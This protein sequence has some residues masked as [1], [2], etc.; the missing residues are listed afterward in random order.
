M[1]KLELLAPAKNVE[2][3]IEAI[4][5]GADAVYI[6]ASKFGARSSASNDIRDIEKLCSHAHLYN[7]KVYAALNTIIFEHELK[8]AEKLIHQLWNAGIDALIIQDM[9]ILE[10]DIPDIPLFASTQTDNRSVEKIQLFEKVGFKRIILAREL[11]LA[12]IE[13][14]SS[15]TSI[16]LEA[17]IHGAL[18]VAYSG[19][20]Y[21]SASLGNRSANRGECGQPCRLPWNLVSSDGIIMDRDRHLL[22]LKDMNRSDHLLDL[23]RAGITSFKIEGRLKDVSYVRNITSFYRKTLDDI[24]DRYGEFEKASSG[25]ASLPF[26]PDPNKTFNRGYTDYFLKGRG[27]IHS[28][29]TPKFVGELIGIVKKITDSCILADLKTTLHNGDGLSFFDRSGKLQGFNVNRVENS[30]LFPGNRGLFKQKILEGGIKLF[31]NHDHE[32]LRQ[33]NAGGVLRKLNISLL[34]YETKDG[35]KLAAKDEDGNLAE[36]SL[37]ILHEPAKNKE[38]AF[39]T[40]RKQLIKTG[41]TIFNVKDLKIKTKP[42]FIQKSR[43]NELR[44]ALMDKLMKLRI[45]AFKREEI[46]FE[47]NEVLY[48]ESELDFSANIANSLA[49]KFYRRHG[50]EKFEPAFELTENLRAKSSTAP[51]MRTKYCLRH[52][53]GLCLKKGNDSEPLYLQNQKARLK[54]E[55]DC[56]QCEMIIRLDG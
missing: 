19:Q 11:S 52:A 24:I 41:N 47:K 50:V 31:R 33:L 12:E 29:E 32:Y 25:K 45:K 49:E 1:K 22:S 9:G 55:F 17:F 38:A 23:I 10:M 20:C 15:E 13:N 42:Y 28:F 37:H 18:C 5:Y 44:R 35:F 54:L 39:E 7:A 21:L 16:E 48:P 27:P 53:F 30:E 56:N 26:I 40:I 3:G 36:E 14:I 43:L 51:V 34:F 2:Y 6:G 8:E 46:V 4:N